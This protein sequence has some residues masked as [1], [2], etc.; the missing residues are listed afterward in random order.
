MSEQV[1]QD[2]AEPVPQELNFLDS[3]D[4]LRRCVAEL[5][6]QDEPDLD[7]LIPLVD[8]ALGA[9]K[10]CKGRIEAVQAMLNERL[11]G[12]EARPVDSE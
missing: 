6:Q 8:K 11:V 9:Y 3:Y 4:T 7:A 10:H 12:E 2:S 1:H 5:R